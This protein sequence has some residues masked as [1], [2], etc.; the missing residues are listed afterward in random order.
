MTIVY[1]V[2]A[3]LLLGLGVGWY[4]GGLHGKAQLEALQASEFKALAD[5]YQAQVLAKQ[6]SEAKLATVE[7]AYDAIKDTPDPATLGT[8]R[9]VLLIAAR[10]SCPLPG[11]AT[12]A[13]GTENPAPLA[14]GPSAVERALDAYVQA[15]SED[16]KQ[17]AAVIQLAP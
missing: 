2:I 10:D 1:A 11:A 13:G 7:N 8:A 6:Q 4:F 16:A 5:A 9:R 12:V 17:L 15:C 14:I 3:A